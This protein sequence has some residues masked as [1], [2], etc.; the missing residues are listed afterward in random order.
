MIPYL[1]PPI[2]PSI[3]DYRCAAF[4]WQSK[5]FEF[6]GQEQHTPDPATGL[7]CIVDALMEKF[8]SKDGELPAT[9]VARFVTDPLNFVALYLHGMNTR[10]LPEQ[11]DFQR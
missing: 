1:G 3:F 5:G 2:G 6:P 11:P 4:Y 10:I 7:A 9:V 8:P